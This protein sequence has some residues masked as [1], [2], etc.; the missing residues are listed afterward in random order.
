MIIEAVII[1]VGI[2]LAGLVIGN[3]IPNRIKLIVELPENITLDIG[4]NNKLNIELPETI[5][6]DIAQ[7]Q[8]KKTIPLSI[9]LENDAGDY[10][11]KRF[12]ISM[13]K[14]DD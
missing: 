5:S 8:G 12:K 3:N 1:A 7:K 14:M 2:V 9:T 10:G 4:K 11:E 6:L 13:K